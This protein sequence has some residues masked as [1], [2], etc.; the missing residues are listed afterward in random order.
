MKYVGF[1]TLPNQIQRKSVRKGFEF[2][3]MVVGEQETQ[4]MISYTI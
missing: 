3:L 4:E 1:A 2:T